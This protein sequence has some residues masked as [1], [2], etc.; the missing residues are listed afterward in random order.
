MATSRPWAI[1]TAV[2]AVVL[3]SVACTSGPR[4]A[5]PGRVSV[6]PAELPAPSAGGAV[7]ARND[8]FVLYSAGPGDT[9]AS[10]AERFLGS[11][12]RAWEIAKFNAIARTEA[13]E[14][15]VIPLQPVNPRGVS[16]TGFQTIPI[17]TYHRFGPKASKMVVTPD[18]FATQLD[19]LARNGY[20]VV[21]LA[22]LTDFLAGTRGLP[23]RAVV[24]TI[25]D[26]HASMYEHAYPLLKKHGFPATFFLYSDFIGA[27]DALR[28]PQIREMA[29]SGLIDFQSHSK[30]H[31]N[32]VE[33][34]PGESDQRYRERL[35]SEIRVPQEVLERN[36][37]TTVTQYAYPY[38]DANEAVLARLS[39]ADY[40]LG[41]TVNP[42]GN[43]FFALPLMLRRSMVFGDH[44]LEGFKALLQVF[45]PVDLR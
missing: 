36:L 10:L 23:E 6:L 2:A 30:T 27:G 32:L 15:I 44:D 1:G 7:V 38:G 43:A 17:L 45:R 24:I 21:R 4:P 35:E 18:A 9:L 39:A 14:V 8:R 16:I 40:E 22:E 33:R 29:A 41:V 37:A 11:E 12:A 3:A 34:L 19:Y 31:A 26:G 28:W 20:R 25:D 5:T 13:G 42:G